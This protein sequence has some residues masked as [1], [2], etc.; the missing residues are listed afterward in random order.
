MTTF[1][2]CLFLACFVG[3]IVLIGTA[4]MGQCP[5]GGCQ[6]PVT[7][8]VSPPATPPETCTPAACTP[9]V[10]AC[11]PAK[12]H[13]HAISA[14]RRPIIRTCHPLANLIARRRGR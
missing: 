5:P 7:V 8:Y 2:H 1:L 10:T 6:V 9:A 3:L 11:G 14:C 12:H 4:A 13:G